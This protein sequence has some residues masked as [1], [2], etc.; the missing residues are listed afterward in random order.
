MTDETMADYWRDVKPY[1]VQESIRKR[2]ANRESSTS[3]LKA[4]SIEFESRN[5]GIHLIVRDADDI[6]DF[7]PGTGLWVKRGETRKYRGVRKLICRITANRK[8][9]DEGS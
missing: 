8:L 7:W 1:M 6:Y 4:S 3:L 2:K 5:N 9:Q